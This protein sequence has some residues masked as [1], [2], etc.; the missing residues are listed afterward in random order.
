MRYSTDHKA[1][2]RE[3]VLTEASRAIRADGVAKVSVATVMSRV[4]LTHGGFYAHFKSKDDLVAH[5]ISHMFD[6]RYHGFLSRVD[7]PDPERTLGEFIRF[8][9][10]MEHRNNVETGCPV[11]ALTSEVSHF[12]PT[13]RERFSNGSQRLIAAIA[14]LLEKIGTD[15][16]K[17][18]AASAFAE[19]VGALALARAAV[20]DKTARQILATSTESVCERLGLKALP[21]KP[22]AKRVVKPKSVATAAPK[23][24]PK[25]AAATVSVKAPARARVPRAKALAS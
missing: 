1:Q 18:R 10:S 22:A 2:T 3:R 20:D 14:D 25:V 24:E 16:A 6:E 7:G 13:A 12:S 23:P 4:G 17:A 11:P 8:Y 15:R 5:S 21:A 9:L 19:A